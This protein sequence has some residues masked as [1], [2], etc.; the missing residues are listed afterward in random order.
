V[1]QKSEGIRKSIIAGSW[2]PSQPHRLRDSIESFLSKVEAK[3]IEGE[4]MGLIAPHAGY[5]YS[6]QV[7]AHAYKQLRRN[8][9]P[10]QTFD[11]VAVI[12]PL[13]R[14][15]LGEFATPQAAHYETPLGLVALDTEAVDAL[16][17]AVGLNRARADN[18]HSLEIQLPFL[19]VVLGEFRLLPVMMGSQSLASCQR[20]A[21]ALADLLRRRSALLVAST[22]LSHFYPYRRAMQIDRQTLQYIDRFDPQG[23]ARALE[24][25][26]AEA[27]GGGPVVTAMLS[28]RA[29]GA[30]ETKVLKYA[31][32]GDVTGDRG[33]VVGYAAGVIYRERA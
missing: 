22:D 33:S 9:S 14:M 30:D 11:L 31:N 26:E 21:D 29:L 4:L 7:A 24:S 16:D 27:C 6:G 13:H 19:Q 17:Q 28:A 12:S 8:G 10:I 18:E 25:G 15:P 32:S 20:L 23:L 5:A 3:P 1:Q 2:Y